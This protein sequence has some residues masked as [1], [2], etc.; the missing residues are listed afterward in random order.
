[1]TTRIIRPGFTIIELIIVI[2]IFAITAATTLPFLGRFQQRETLSTIT[3]DVTRA[4][5]TAQHKAMSGE[6]DTQWGVRFEPATYILYAGKSYKNRLQQFDRRRGVP[7]TLIF[8]GEQEINFAKRTGAPV[9]GSGILVLRPPEGEPSFI[10]I[11][12]AG[13]IFTEKQE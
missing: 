10:S 3:D 8:S 2:A 5:R 11:N 9:F 1:M 12:A 4:L 6:Q 7:R 13:G